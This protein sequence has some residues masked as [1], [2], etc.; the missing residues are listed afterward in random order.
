M[1]VICDILLLDELA[2][3]S[4]LLQQLKI[5]SPSTT[6]D[7]NRV[8]LGFLGLELKRIQAVVILMHFRNNGVRSLN[9]PIKY[10]G[11]LLTEEEARESA[12]RSLLGSGKI[13]GS[14]KRPGKV[15]NPM[16]WNFV[17]D[18]PNSGHGICE[19]GGNM[20]VDALDGHIWSADELEEFS[21]DY[22]NAI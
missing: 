22:L 8:Y 15:R 11:R 16:F 10:K 6:F 20:V 1:Q 13:I 4:K 18:Q 5:F 2:G 19:G 3:S 14:M 17:W 21:Y 7:E 9:I 12:E